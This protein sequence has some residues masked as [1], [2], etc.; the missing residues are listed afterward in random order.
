MLTTPI[1]ATDPV[2]RMKVNRVTANTKGSCISF[3]AQ[4][5]KRSLIL[6]PMGAW[7]LPDFR[8]GLGTEGGFDR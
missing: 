4:I 7:R 2:C 5:A 1:T 6:I 8:H 3:S